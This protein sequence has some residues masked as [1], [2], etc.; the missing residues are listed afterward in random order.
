[1]NL[2]IDVYYCRWFYVVCLQICTAHNL[3]RNIATSTLVAVI[4]TSE[5]R[6][7]SVLHWSGLK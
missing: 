7:Q 1:M 2:D 4:F 6:A 3:L 5:T